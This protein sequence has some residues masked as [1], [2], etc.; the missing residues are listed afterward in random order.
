MA[1][2]G[3]RKTGG[4]D[5]SQAPSHLLRRCVQHANDLF[6]REPGSRELTRQQFIVLAAAEQNDGV[7]QTDLVNITGIDRSTLAEMI[8][9]MIERGVLGRERTESDQRANAVHISPQGRKALKSAR[10]ANDRVEKAL[11]SA[12]SAADRTK[13]ARMLGAIVAKAE[14]EEVAAPVRRRRRARRK[15]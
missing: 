10:A 9:R 7:S 13:L 8:R 12:L 15:R 11:V 5:L 14:A 3:P 1:S 2:K 6:S 4:F